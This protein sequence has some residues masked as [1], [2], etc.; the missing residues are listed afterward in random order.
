MIRLRHKLFVY[1]MRGLDP[2]VLLGSVLVVTGLSDPARSSSLSQ[3]ILRDAYQSGDGVGIAVLVIGWVVIFNILIQYDTDRF[4]TLRSELLDVAKATTAAAALLFVVGTVLWTG[5]ISNTTILLVWAVATVILVLSRVLARE[6]LMLV[7]RSGYNYR[8][9]LVIGYNAQALEIASRIDGLPEL[10]YKLVGFISE[11][12]EDAP[13]V[14]SEGDSPIVGGLADVQ[15]ILEH[16]PVDEMII[17]LPMR[18]HLDTIFQSIRLAQELGIVVRLFPDAAGSS[19]LMRLQV[20]RFGGDRVVT[21]FRERMVLQLLGK[22]VLDTTLSAVLLLLLSPMLVTVALA[23]KLTSA[24]PVFF[25]QKRVGMNRRT[26]NLYK[27]RSMY[28]DAEKRRLELAHLNEMDGPVFKIRNDPRVTALGRLLRRT[29]ID[30]LPQLFNV[31]RGHLSLVG[32]RP[33]LPEEVER[34]EWLYRRRLSIKP[35]ITCFWQVSGRNQLT[36]KQWMELDNKYIDNWS[37][38]LDIKILARTI[39][40]VLFLRGAS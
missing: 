4:A 17:C 22:R 23:I 30:E 28:L 13:P 35:G 29:S 6:F 20:E 7:R 37:L 39:P 5:R 2:A 8:H 38:W 3:W 11:G 14:S 31:L 18:E 12:S 16:R 33:P 9:L 15:R 32:P 19:I 10:G 24:G 21:L 27:F 25:V 34:Y 36:F 1:L 26:F 40:A